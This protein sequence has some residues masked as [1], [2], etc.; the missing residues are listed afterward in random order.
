MSKPALQHF[1]KAQSTFEIP[2]IANENAYLGD[3]STRYDINHL[4]A[5]MQLHRTR[6]AMFPSSPV[7]TSVSRS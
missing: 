5:I 4:E 1:P 6:N 3:I 7:T 2:L